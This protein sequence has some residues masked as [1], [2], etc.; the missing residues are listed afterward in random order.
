MVRLVFQLGQVGTVILRIS[1]FCKLK[2]KLTI[3][4]FE[5]APRCIMLSGQLDLKCPLQ[6]V[7]L[8]IDSFILN[9]V[10]VLVTRNARTSIRS[11]VPRLPGHEKQYF[12]LPL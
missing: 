5:F 12:G 6:K 8:S 9:I 3:Y 4:F 11:K 10:S 2:R 1:N 7:R